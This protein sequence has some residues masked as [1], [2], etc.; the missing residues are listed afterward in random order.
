MPYIGSAAGITRRAK[1]ARVVGRSGLWLVADMLF[2]SY[3][4]IFLFLPIA[5]LGSFALGRF[6]HLAAIIWLALASLAFYAIGNWQFVPLL[7]G[8]IAF[9]Y[10]AGYFL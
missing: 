10:A 4:F 8:S 5:L 1:R 3:A 7:A 2:N 9:N 6:G